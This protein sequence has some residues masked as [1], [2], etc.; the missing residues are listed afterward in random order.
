MYHELFAIQ[1]TNN[2]RFF[3]GQPRNLKWSEKI[4]NVRFYPNLKTAQG[5]RTNINN[6]LAKF[7]L[8]DR[9]YNCLNI[10]CFELRPGIPF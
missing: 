1:N 5:I 6:H 9:D 2:G 8:E 7:G 10:I 3:T 4:H